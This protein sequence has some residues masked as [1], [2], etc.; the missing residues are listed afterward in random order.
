LVWKWAID[1]W[2]VWFSFSRFL[3]TTRISSMDVDIIPNTLKYDT[4]KWWVIHNVKQQEVGN[5]WLL[6]KFLW[7]RRVIH[8]QL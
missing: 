8:I 1:S 5:M 3:R 6:E 2:S 4:N 7:R